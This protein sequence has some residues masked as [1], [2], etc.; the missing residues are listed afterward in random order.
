MAYE[1]GEWA[2]KLRGTLDSARAARALDGSL[3]AEAISVLTGNDPGAAKRLAAALEG[4]VGSL[5]AVGLP[6]SSSA[7]QSPNG[8]FN[9]SHSFHGLMNTSIP[10]LSPALK[11][12][13]FLFSH[14]DYCVP[15][16]TNTFVCTSGA[17]LP[18]LP[19]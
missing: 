18:S 10:P 19:P 1:G 2:A 8:P 16:Y 15:R 13:K 11:K 4:G 17:P 3:S 12:N 5:S 9:P 7:S 14:R 6:L